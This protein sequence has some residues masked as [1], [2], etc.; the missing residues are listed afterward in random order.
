M[1]GQASSPTVINPR[2]K[3]QT[4]VFRLSHKHG[5]AHVGSAFCCSLIPSQMFHVLLQHKAPQLNPPWKPRE[6]SGTPVSPCAAKPDGWELVF[7]Q[8]IPTLLTQDSSGLGH[9]HG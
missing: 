5:C 8:V 2:G 1:P 6:A 7:G 3:T 9:G 4:R